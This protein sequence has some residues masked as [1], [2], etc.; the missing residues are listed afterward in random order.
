MNNHGRHFI[1]PLF[2]QLDLNR[3]CSCSDIAIAS[4]VWYTLQDTIQYCVGGGI[5][6]HFLGTAPKNPAEVNVGDI[7]VG[8]S[9]QTGTLTVH[10]KRATGLNV[11]AP[12]KTP[13]P[14]VRCYLLPGI[15]PSSKRKSAVQQGTLKPEWNEKFSYQRLSLE[16]LY[17]SVLEL[18]V[19]SDDPEVNSSLIFCVIYFT[20]LP[21]ITTNYEL[22]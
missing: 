7:Q 1:S 19:W 3:Y 14:F 4:P 10:V 17:T 22:V 18:T 8:V 20:S 5:N 6:G 13:N 9:F 12:G 2:F 16:D 21:L 11:L 15:S